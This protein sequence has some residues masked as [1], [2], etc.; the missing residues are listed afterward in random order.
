MTKNK[1][2]PWILVFLWMSLI[3][4]LSHQAASQSSQ[5]SRGL[6]V[7]IINIIEKVAPNLEVEFDAFD[8]FVRKN[9][10]FFAYLILG[11][12][13]ANA[14]RNGQANRSFA[15]IS[16][17]VLYALSDEFHQTFIPGRAGQWMDILIDSAG[18]VFGVLS[19]QIALSIKKR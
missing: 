4:Y 10:H 8:Y 7:T 16:L 3:F 11:L 9:A 14:M 15:A 6:T 17:C 5:L 18:S 19:Y 1:A 12:L 2:F 13:V